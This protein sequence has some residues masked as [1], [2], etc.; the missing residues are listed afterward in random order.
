MSI[1]EKNTLIEIQQPNGDVIREYPITKLENILGIDKITEMLSGDVIVKLN[2]LQE[3]D[4]TMKKALMLLAVNSFV[5]DEVTGDTYKIGSRDGQFFYEK[6][7]VSVK[8]LL[9]T[10]AT[11]IGT[12]EETTNE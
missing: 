3:V 1:V 11:A 8:D 2:S 7:D 5:V 9:D 10:L 12:S 4:E 6:S